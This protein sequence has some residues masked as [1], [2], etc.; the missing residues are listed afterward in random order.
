MT[1]STTSG[2]ST[3]F[4]KPVCL[5]LCAVFLIF[6]SRGLLAGYS[7]WFDEIFSVSASLDTWQQLY[8]RWILQSDVHPPLYHII[9]K[10]W[11]LLFGSSE[12]ATRLLSFMFVCVSLSAFSFDAIAGKR[13]RRVTA[14]LFIAASP[15]F[16]YYAQETR[17]YSLVLALSSIVT[18]SILE[19][20]SQQKKSE[21]PSGKFLS[22]IFYAGAFLLSVTHYFGW[23]YVFVISAIIFFENRIKYARSRAVLLVA[24]ISLWPIWHVVIGSLGAHTGGNFWINIAPPFIGTLNTFLSGCLPFLAINGSESLFVAAWALIAALIMASASSWNSIGFF[25][26]KSFPEIGVIADE[27]RFPL[28]S[29][30]L[31]VMLLSL[32]DIH[33]P[34]ST[35]R[36]Y[37]VLLPP[38]M[39]VLANSLTI[40]ANVRGGKSPAGK[41]STFLVLVIVLLLAR[42]SWS[43][44]SNKIQAP[45][46]W[47]GLSEYVKKTKICSDGCFVMGSLG[48][49]NFYFSGS[50]SFYDLSSSKG[51][52]EP[53]WP[54]ISLDKQ[55]NYV[56]P[57]VDAIIMGFHSASSKV[58]GLMEASKDRECIQPSQSVEVFLI[59]PK[60]RLT[61]SEEKY[62]MKKCVTPEL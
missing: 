47:K 13:W 14:L 1:S 34:M 40:L 25:F 8:Q 29:T 24:M 37:I 58:A 50:G 45:Q 35:A 23:I 17:S 2:L 44:L 46:N 36:N 4:I 16:A 28:L 11:M 7:Y 33:T 5:V 51:T 57:R 60:S 41:A 21:L 12:I 61:G 38:V 55:Y 52:L 9:L 27:V 59:L 56:K 15:S 62:G 3:R 39:I 30:A 6:A 42:Q 20:R 19:L 26:S 31:M 49:H 43:G 48:L 10:L 54:G 32:I 53:I 22:L 18:L